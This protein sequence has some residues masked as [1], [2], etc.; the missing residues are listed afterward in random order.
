MTVVLHLL[1]STVWNGGRRA[2]IVP[3]SLATEGFVHCTADDET[4]LRV[5]NQFYTKVPGTMVAISIDLDRVSA[6][7]KWEHPPGSDPLTSIAFPHVYGPIPRTS[8]VSSRLMQRAD[9][10]SYTGYGPRRAVI[11]DS[12]PILPSRDL[13][14]TAGWYEQLGFENRIVYPKQ[15]LM[16]QRDGFDL[17]F[18]YQQ[19]L[20]PVHNDHGAYIWVD[21]AAALHAEWSTSGA[22]GKHGP[23]EHT[24]YGLDEGHYIDPDGNLIRYGS[25]SR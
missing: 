11:S 12:A 13:E 16:L 4:L 6:E 25:P 3:E 9:D 5:A 14:A 23:P 17:H 18:F 7:V 2:P 1:P 8:V 21:D 15:Y 20:F 10:G 24:D 19:N 22:P